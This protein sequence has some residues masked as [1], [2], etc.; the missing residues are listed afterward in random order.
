M[1]DARVRTRDAVAPRVTQDVVVDELLQVYSDPTVGADDDIRANTD[2]LGHVSV[3]VGKL[4]V[5]GV[6][7]NPVLQLRYC[8]GSQP[9]GECRLGRRRSRLGEHKQSQDQVHHPSVS[10]TQR[11]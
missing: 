1:V 7:P 5:R 10:V 11:Q 2:A 3:R 4:V 6:I 8:C 9:V